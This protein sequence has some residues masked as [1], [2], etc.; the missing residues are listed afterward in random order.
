MSKV[1]T[2]LP[3]LRRSALNNRV[4]KEKGR[5]LFFSLVLLFFLL[6]VA[7]LP[8][9]SI[10]LGISYILHLILSPLLPW[11]GRLKINRTLAVSILLVVVGFLTIYPI[12]RIVPLIQSEVGNLHRYMPKIESFVT[13]DYRKYAHILYEKTGIELKA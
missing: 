10:P 2:S 6:I 11:M 3:T 13:K 4:R 8:R 5:I 1:T 12:V 7:F 9:L